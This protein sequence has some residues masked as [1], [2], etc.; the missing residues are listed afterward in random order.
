MKTINHHLE[1]IVQSIHKIYSYT[2]GY[3]K[4]DIDGDEKT[5]DAC[6]MQLQVIGEEASKIAKIDPAFSAL[7]IR[8]MVS[9]RNYISHDYANMDLDEVR[10]VITR[11]LPA[12]EKIITDLLASY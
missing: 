5:Y 6:L 8:V 9:M 4:D 11:D 10:V 2:S 7:P 1:M 3:D 12:I